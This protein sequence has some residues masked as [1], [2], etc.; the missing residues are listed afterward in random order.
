[1]L[2][3]WKKN[4]NQNTE[5]QFTCF[6]GY[7]KRMP[8]DLKTLNFNVNSRTTSLV[9]TRMPYKSYAKDKQFIEGQ[10]RSSDITFI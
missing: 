8:K 5:Y 9:F 4:L 6:R 2:L 3:S 10:L 1:M 7:Y